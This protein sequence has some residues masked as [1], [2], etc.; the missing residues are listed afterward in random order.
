MKG[1]APN[2]LVILAN[3]GRPGFRHQ[4]VG[5]GIGTTLK[6][7]RRNWR[8]DVSCA[9][10]TI[11]ISEKTPSP[12]PTPDP[13]LDTAPVL[14]TR[15][16]SGEDLRF[17]DL[18][19]IEGGAPELATSFAVIWEDHAVTFIIRCEEPGLEKMHVSP[20]VWDAD[21]VALLIET[22]TNAYY[23]IEVNPDGGVYDSN[24]GSYVG[25]G[26]SA[27][28]EVIPER[29][30]D[31]WQVSV[32][33]PVVDEETGEADPNHF[34][35]GHLPTSERP[36]FINVGRDRPRAGKKDNSLYSPTGTSY[37]VPEQFVR[38]QV[39]DPYNLARRGHEG[40]GIHLGGLHLL[41][42]C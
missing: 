8:P 28:A 30:D 20:N 1:S 15:K 10:T 22:D 33:L 18:Q 2:L 41:G 25:Q 4:E 27:Q 42:R 5:N 26:W 40:P 3:A 13:R 17:Y 35:I 9:A 36:W 31:F 19:R 38:L 14:A 21:S 7:G 12:T 32:R 29:G 6:R 23:H 34:M 24:R 16:D 37:H 39:A 11:I